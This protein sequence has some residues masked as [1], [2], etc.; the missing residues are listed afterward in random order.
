MP[1]AAVSP[2][3]LRVNCSTSILVFSVRFIISCLNFS[4]ARVGFSLY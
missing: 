2:D 1:K 4:N 3:L